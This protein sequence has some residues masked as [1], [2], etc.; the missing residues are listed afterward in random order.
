M[1]VINMEKERIKVNKQYT[2]NQVAEITGYNP[3]HLRRL[4]VKGE[5]KA[6]KLGNYIWIIDHEDLVEFAKKKGRE[7]S[8]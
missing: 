7:I 8:A 2:V 4:I 5:L 3:A 6:T 1:I